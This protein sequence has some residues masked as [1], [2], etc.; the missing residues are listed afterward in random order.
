MTWN[1]IG[2]DHLKAAKMLAK[3]HPRSSSS[4][5]YYACHVVLTEALTAQGYVPPAG[6][7]TQPH[8]AKQLELI[9]RHLSGRGVRVVRELRRLISRLYTRRLAADYRRTA[10]IDA[11]VALDS[12]RDAS[13]FFVLLSV[14]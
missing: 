4:R 14:R 3:D 8:E 7:Q 13:T 12:L 6:R 10:T 2:K 1:E 9:R 5:A 11:A